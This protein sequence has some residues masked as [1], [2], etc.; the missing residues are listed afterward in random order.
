MSNNAL[1]SLLAV[2]GDLKAVSAKVKNEAILTFHK[3]DDH[4]EGF[5]KIYEAFDEEA[6]NTNNKDEKNVVTTVS[7]K[8]L[9]IKDAISEGLRA[10]LSKE[11]TNSSGNAKSKLMVNGT[12]FGT[13]SATSL[14]ALEKEMV[15]IRKVYSVIPTLDPAKE[16]EP[17]KMAEEDMFKTSPHKTFR[18]SKIEDFKT[19]VQ[20]TKEHPAQI[21]KMVKDV[22]VG[23][24]LTTYKS[25]KISPLMKSKMLKRID[26]II[27][28]VKQ[29]RSKANQAEVVETNIG[30]DLI[31]YI[32]KDLI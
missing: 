5:I 24:Y 23:H 22:T 13:L 2:E 25:G 28:A 4:F 11:E 19:I 12:D 3:K 8:I 29:A 27:L 20:P 10:Q 16:W 21:A 6:S 32:N 14:L 17:D 30:S 26:D 18:T 9:Y 7:S 31:D 15:L 1:H